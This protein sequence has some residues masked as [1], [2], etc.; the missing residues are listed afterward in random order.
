MH[1]RLADESVCIGPPPAK[2]SYLNISALLAAC[3][4][5]GADAVHPGYGFLSENARFA[6][7]LGRAQASISSGRKPEHI[8]L[9]GDKIEAKRTAA[10]LGIPVVPGSDGGVD[11]GRRGA[12][13]S[14]ATSASRAGQGVG[15]RRRT[16]HEGRAHRGRPFRRACDRARR[17]QSRLRR[18]CR[19]S[20]EIPAS[21]RA[22]S[23]S[24]CSA[25]ARAPPSTSA[26]ATARCS[27]AIRRSGRK[28][29]RPRS[30]RRARP[31]RRDRRQGDARARNISASAPSSSCTRTASSIS[32]R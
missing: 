26:S 8:R 5:T 6:E 21:G 22:I 28:A 25:T 23:R 9:M 24:R 19:L 30:T 31:D 27:A 12:S 14:R 1:V 17:S 10:R 15:R 2:D 13:R 3:E 32:S 20:R 7:I 29:P 11:V 4:I 16:R 18:R